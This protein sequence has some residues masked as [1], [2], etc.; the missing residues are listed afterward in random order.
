MH[1]ASASVSILPGQRPRPNIRPPQ[2][3]GVDPLQPVAFL[4]ACGSSIGVGVVKGVDLLVEQIKV[5][6]RSTQFGPYVP[7]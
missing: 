3:K 2:A 4:M 7:R 1:K 5:T 6:P